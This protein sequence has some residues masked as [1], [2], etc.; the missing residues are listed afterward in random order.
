MKPDK[1]KPWSGALG[2]LHP[3]VLLADLCLLLRR[4]VVHDVERLAD[5]L[6]RLA[7]DHAGHLGAGEVQEGLD[8]HVVCSQDQ[9]KQN[10]LV[11]LVHKVS[12]PLR[13]HLLHHCTLE[14]LFDLWHGVLHMLLAKLHNLGQDRA[15]HVRQRDLL[16]VLL[17]LLL[18]IVTT[19]LAQHG[20]HQLRHGRRLGA[21]L[22][23]LTVLRHEEHLAG[24]LLLVSSGSGSGIGLLLLGHCW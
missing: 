11:Q 24:E 3:L 5:L 15:L 10:L 21:H 20:L 9:L 1:Q 19:G 16:G 14:R 13:N 17:I 18:L 23:L 2:L 8:V 7:L 4:E 6:R 12:I 22:E